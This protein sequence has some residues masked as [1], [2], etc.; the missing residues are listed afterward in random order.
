MNVLVTASTLAWHIK[1]V[2]LSHDKAAKKPGKR[3]RG[4][5]DVGKPRTPYGIHPVWAAMTILHERA[6]APELRCKGAKALLYHDVLEDTTTCLPKNISKDVRELV[7]GMTFDDFQEEKVLIWQRSSEVRL[8]SLYEKTSNWLDGDWL[9]PERRVVHREHL[10][11]L[12]YD[13]EKNW[14]NLNIIIIARA[15][16]EKP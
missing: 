4:W 2:F 9:Y 8:L 11:K 14:G 1:R 13:V 15:L 7:K 16:L 6:L 5:K 10:A 12:A 3:F